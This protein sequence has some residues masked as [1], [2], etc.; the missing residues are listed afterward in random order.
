[1]RKFKQSIILQSL[2]KQVPQ[3]GRPKRQTDW[4]ATVCGS[5]CKN[6]L[7]V[8]FFYRYFNDESVI[9]H[10]VMV[11]EG[12]ISVNAVPQSAVIPLHHIENGR[13]GG[14]GLPFKTEGFNDFQVVRLV[15][16]TISN[17]ETFR[18]EYILIILA[19]KPQF[20]DDLAQSCHFC[21]FDHNIG[22]C[23]Y[24]K[25]KCHTSNWQRN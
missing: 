1:M 7:L 2:R 8:P 11:A 22:F 23:Y 19:L 14:I 18:R 12:T 13:I 4:L 10:I 21:W 20:F 9:I 3:G 24:S 15:K 5:V 17:S 25:S 6:Q 16:L